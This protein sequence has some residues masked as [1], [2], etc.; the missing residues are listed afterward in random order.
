MQKAIEQAAEAKKALINQNSDATQEEKM[1]R[2]KELQMKL[3]MLI[4][5]LTNLQIMMVLMKYKRTVLVQLI[6]FNL[7]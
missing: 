2:F 5:L 7:K 4:D 3:E 6:I 1:Q